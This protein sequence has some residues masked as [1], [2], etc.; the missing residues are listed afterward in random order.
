MTRSIS[1]C[2]LTDLERNQQPVQLVDVRSAAEFRTGHIPG[3]VN[4][5]MEEIEGRLTDLNPRLPVVL[6]CQAGARAKITANRLQARQ[7][8]CVVLEGG[9]NSWVAASLRRSPPARYV[10]RSNGK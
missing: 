6:V 9:T 7:I 2:E 4:I 5:P 8:E 3:A 1:V 10:G